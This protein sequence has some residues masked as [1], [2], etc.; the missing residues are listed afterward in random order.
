VHRTYKPVPSANRSR[1]LSLKMPLREASLGCF[2][3]LEYRSEEKL[4]NPDG[5]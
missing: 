5:I 4:A 1:W 3:P 2:V